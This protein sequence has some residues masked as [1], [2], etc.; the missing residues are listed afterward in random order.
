MLV[1]HLFWW[2]VWLTL[3]DKYFGDI[4]VNGHQHSDITHIIVDETVIII[5]VYMEW[6]IHDA[7]RCDLC[8]DFYCQNSILKHPRGGCSIWNLHKRKFRK[9]N[10]LNGT[11][12]R[13][14]KFVP[15]PFLKNMKL[16][17]SIA[18]LGAFVD[19]NGWD[20][21]ALVI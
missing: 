18:V 19:A 3:W 7:T 1:N 14:C 4:L 13:R 11:I 10:T 12:K 20:Q 16:T 17:S 5:S 2:Q 21:K 9:L 8:L 15:L 6:I